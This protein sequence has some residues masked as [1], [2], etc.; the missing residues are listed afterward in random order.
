VNNIQPLKKGVPVPRKPREL[1]DGGIYHIIQRG[2]HKK[3]VFESHLDYQ[4][5]I[6]LLMELC[7][8]YGLLVYHYCLMP[9][10]VHLMVQVAVGLNL[11]KFGH[12]LFR[13]YSKWHQAQY[14]LT[15]HLW[16]GRFKSPRVDEES[17]FL[18]LGRYI[19]RNPVRAKLVADL[20]EYR[21]SSYCYYALG[22]P[23]NLVTTDPYYEDLGNSRALRQEQYRSYVAWSHPHDD[24]LDEVLVN[25]A[26]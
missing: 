22:R 6:S 7:K 23:D 14:G 21:W 26:I 16:Q 1:V 20:A 25:K 18:E 24:K 8:K 10:H 17:Y 13:G 12:A 19:E 9:N 5:F 11:P 2:N 3:K 4:H 15:G